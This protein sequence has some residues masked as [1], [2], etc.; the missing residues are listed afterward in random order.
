MWEK[1]NETGMNSY[2]AHVPVPFETQLNVEYLE[3]LPYLAL[4]NGPTAHCM[5]RR[6]VNTQKQKRQA[7]CLAALSVR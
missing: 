1:Y 7:Q 6:T 5:R 3:S 2:F 4:P